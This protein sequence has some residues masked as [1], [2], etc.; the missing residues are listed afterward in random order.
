[1]PKRVVELLEPVDVDHQHA[2]PVF[3]A[4]AAGEEDHVLVEVAAVWQARERV[5][6]RAGLG[7]A[8][9]VDPGERGGCLDRCG[10]QDPV[11]AGGPGARPARQDDRALHPAVDAERCGGEIAQAVDVAQAV[12]DAVRDALG[13]ALARWVRVT[14]PTRPHLRRG[15]RDA[16]AA[17]AQRRPVPGADPGPSS[18]DAEG[19]QLR[20]ATRIGDDRHGGQ[21]APARGGDG[22][23]GQ[24]V[25][26][27]GVLENAERQRRARR[28]GTGSA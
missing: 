6:G 14:R 20:V 13:G 19:H 16:T 11:R 18:R 4:P 10:L 9:R 28:R 23:L 5:G 26:F 12:R 7:V 8:Q 1:M 2:H 21:P 15:H 27:G 3:G 24:G 22:Q 17:L 25:G